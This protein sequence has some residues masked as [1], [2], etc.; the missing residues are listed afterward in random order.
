MKTSEKVSSRNQLNTCWSFFDQ[1]RVGV[2]VC[3]HGLDS[4]QISPVKFSRFND[5]IVFNVPQVWQELKCVDHDSFC[6]VLVSRLEDFSTYHEEQ[7]QL[8]IHGTATVISFD[9]KQYA[10]FASVLEPMSNYVAVLHPVSI[11]YD[12]QHVSEQTNYE[13][14][15]IHF[16]IEDFDDECWLVER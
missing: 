2:V 10:K 13:S 3:V 6:S 14:V 8:H 15:E 9:S 7:P 16:S 12:P 11:K 4:V 5:V 1:C